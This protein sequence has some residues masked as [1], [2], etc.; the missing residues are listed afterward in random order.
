M[1]SGLATLYATPVGLDKRAVCFVLG[2]GYQDDTIR[3]VI[4][5]VTGGLLISSL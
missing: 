2:I 5:E 3:G 4:C 1:G